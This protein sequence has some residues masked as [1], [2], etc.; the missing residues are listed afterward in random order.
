MAVKPGG[1]Y[2]HPPVEQALDLP[3]TARVLMGIKAHLPLWRAALQSAL[4]G[5]LVT[6][7]V[8]IAGSGAA[9]EVF[10]LVALAEVVVIGEDQ[11]G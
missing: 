1:T 10:H 5:F 8:G 4:W 11:F 6:A 3:D 9:D 2:S 7:A